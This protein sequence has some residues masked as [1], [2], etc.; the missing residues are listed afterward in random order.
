MST[1]L[2][3]WVFALQGLHVPL[4][5]SLHL[6]WVVL[7]AEKKK[8]VLLEKPVALKVAEFDQIIE[9]CD[10][11]GVQFM[12]GTTWMHHHRTTKMTEIVSDP[13][14]FGNPKMVSLDGLG[15]LGDAGW[16]C[17]RAILWA[18]DYE[19]PK[20]VTAFHGSVLNEGVIL[21]CGSYLQWEEGKTAT[22]NC[23]FL[24]NLT[25]NI[26]A[27]GTK[28]TLQV[29]DFVHPYEEESAS[30]TAVSQIGLTAPALPSLHVVT[31]DL[32][33]EASMVTDF[34]RLV[35]SI[36]DGGSNQRLSGSA[37]AGRHNWLHPLTMEGTACGVILLGSVLDAGDDGQLHFFDILHWYVCLQACHL[38]ATHNWK[39][40]SQKVQEGTVP[41][42][43]EK[44]KKNDQFF[45]EEEGEEDSR[46]EKKRKKLRKGI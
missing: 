31:T 19:L 37:S 6:R 34:S 36:K 23:S 8:H 11:N 16:Y 2:S 30:F 42:C 38:C 44:K 27:I 4:P 26:T 22:F 41:H 9:A 12:D 3:L 28:G 10:V 29:H 5:T 7:A 24:T 35:K 18:F 43:G 1:H 46:L 15:A 39:V 32:P 45:L 13:V 40:L 20:T 25:M 21:A 17:V 33:Q 14:H